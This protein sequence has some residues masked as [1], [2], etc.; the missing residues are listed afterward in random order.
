MNPN[1]NEGTTTMMADLGRAHLAPMGLA[2]EGVTVDHGPS[3]IVDPE[4]LA[5]AA[6]HVVDTVLRRLAEPTR[7][8]VVAVIVG[9]VG[10]PG[11]SELAA[12]LDIPVVGIGQAS[13]LAASGIGRPFGMAPSTPLLARSLVGLVEEHDGSKAF[14]GVR[15]TRSEPLVLAADPERQY[16]ELA[17]A[18]RACAE[19]D[20]AEAVIIAGGPLSESARRLAALDFVEIVEPL[21]SATDLVI[22]ALQ[23]RA[24]TSNSR[25]PTRL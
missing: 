7:G 14:T 10:D 8:A 20:G 15:F 21:P 2:V 4:S 1:T 16:R 13:I 11:R 23:D 5:D 19:E 24:T 12:Q 22:D 25:L 3:M 9:A 6:A 18:V 17:A